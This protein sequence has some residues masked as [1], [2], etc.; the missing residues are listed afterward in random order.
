VCRGIRP[1]HAV[2]LRTWPR[3]LA[4]SRI[5][6]RLKTGDR[7]LAKLFSWAFTDTCSERVPVL[8]PCHFSPALNP[9]PL[10]VRLLLI[11][12]L[13]AAVGIAAGYELAEWRLARA[14]WDGRPSLVPE[15]E[16]PPLPKP[17]DPAPKA[18][19]H[20]TEYKFGTMGSSEER[21]HEFVFGNTGA[22]PLLLKVG[23]T[24][25][26]C[27]KSELEKTEV[28]PGGTSKFTLR[29]KAREM[30]GPFRQSA[31]VYTNDPTRPEVTLVVSGEITVPV[32]AEPEE[33]MFTHLPTG[34]PA[35]GEVRVWCTLPEPALQIPDFTL[36]DK[37]IAQFFEIRFLPL[38]PEQLR[39]DPRARSG[40]LIRVTVKPGLPQGQFQQTMLLRTNLVSDP[41]LT[42]PIKGIVEEGVVIAGLGWDASTA[43]L[44]LGKV[45]GDEGTERTLMVTVPGPQPEDVEVVRTSPESLRA[46]L[47]K[48]VRDKNGTKTPLII[49]IPKGSQSA[50]HL[51]SGQGELGE[52]VLKTHH[53]QTSELRIL[54]RFAVTKREG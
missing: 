47:G 23:S 4:T 3:A 29:W 19:I 30:T 22:A 27:T 18:V 26:R 37:Q 8:E 35:T 2:D 36:S 32:R 43:T 49:Q 44:D 15:P 10:T 28:P 13:A 7:H 53:P 12:V 5:F 6:G 38:S 54:V 20:G 45:P 48:V 25:C 52:V 14:R 17:G 41:A 39:S 40:V 46:K 16:K 1:C 11:L 24:S 21:T 42:I 9:H 33:L 34:R 50:S 31:M 51:G